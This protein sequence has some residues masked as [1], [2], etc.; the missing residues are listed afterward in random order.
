MSMEQQ[1]TENTK[2]GM[3]IGKFVTLIIAIIGAASGSTWTVSQFVTKL[4]DSV[5]KVNVTAED[6]NS[7]LAVMEKKLDR[8]IWT[9]QGDRFTAT[10]YNTAVYISSLKH[11]P[12]MPYTGEI[13]AY[14]LHK[15]PE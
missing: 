5:N 1:I 6:T 12:A 15:K 3:T 9:A 2:V 10:Q 8:A 7:R 14:T 13:E 11:P 4:D